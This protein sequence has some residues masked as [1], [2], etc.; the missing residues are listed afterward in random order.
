VKTQSGGSFFFG[1]DHDD[2]GAQAVT[3]DENLGYI[4]KRTHTDRYI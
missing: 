1:S 4:A 3:G 2:P